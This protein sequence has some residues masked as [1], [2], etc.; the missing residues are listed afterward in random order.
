MEFLIF[1]L[2]I[3]ILYPNL[4]NR[5]REILA[6]PIRILIWIDYLLSMGNLLHLLDNSGEFF[7]NKR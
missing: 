1:F 3:H 5:T 4:I 7:Y 2:H 6:K